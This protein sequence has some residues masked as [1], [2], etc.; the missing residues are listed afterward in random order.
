MPNIWKPSVTVAAIIT[1]GDGAHRQFLMIEETTKDGNRI[2][3]AAGHLDPNESV[4]QAVIREVLEETAHDFVPEAL[5]GT[6]LSRYISP[7]TREEVTYLRF[8]F[9]GKVTAQH[10]QALDLGIVC[11]M[12]MSYEEIVASKDRHRSPLVL[13]CVEDYLAGQRASLDLL[14]THPSAIQQ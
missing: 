8:A 4:E 10:D 7:T 13:R 6:Y 3:Q 1:R 14:Y 2:N 9:C 5:V 11:T 12:W